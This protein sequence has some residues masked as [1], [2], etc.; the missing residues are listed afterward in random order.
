MP[1][2]AFV[3]NSRDGSSQ[4]GSIRRPSATLILCVLA[5]LAW[6]PSSFGGS[7]CVRGSVTCNNNT[8]GTMRTCSASL[9]CYGG[10]GFWAVSSVSATNVTACEPTYAN[11]ADTSTTFNL[12]A[13]AMVTSPTNRLCGWSFG[14]PMRTADGGIQKRGG[15]FVSITTGDGLPVELMDFSIDGDSTA[16]DGSPASEPDSE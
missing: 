6:A 13:R 14:Q 7:G 11:A 10:I 1:S 2:S 3:A 5:A 8:A 9:Q 4:T 12:I 15:N 16:D